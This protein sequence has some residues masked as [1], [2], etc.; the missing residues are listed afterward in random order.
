MT[1]E[2]KRR[3][4]EAVKFQK[5]LALAAGASNRFEAEAA[6]RAARRLMELY[7]IDPVEFPNISFYNRMNFADNPLLKKLRDEWREQHPHY[8]YAK[9]DKDGS[10]RRLRRKPRSK[11]T[12]KPEPVNFDGMFDDFVRNIAAKSER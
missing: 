8:W 10:A 9:I 4:H 11:P 12:A 6:E 3:L 2:H 1:S 5:A 7:N